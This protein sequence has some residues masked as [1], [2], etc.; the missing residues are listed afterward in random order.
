M[1]TN[2]YIDILLNLYSIDA[3]ISASGVNEFDC[4]SAVGKISTTPSLLPFWIIAVLINRAH[5]HVINI[6][7]HQ[8]T[9]VVA[10]VS[11]DDF[12]TLKFQCGIVVD[13]A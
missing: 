3:D 1:K 4:M 11:Q 2:I 13:S 5:F 9:V 8:T 7:I 10:R 6:D 12:A